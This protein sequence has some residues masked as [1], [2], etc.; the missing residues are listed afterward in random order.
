MTEW[1]V[2]DLD[3]APAGYRELRTD[4]VVVP[5]FAPSVFAIDGADAVE[6]LQGQCTNDLHILGPQGLDF[7]FTKPTGQILTLCR[8]WK[9]GD[10]IVVA[11]DDPGV[12]MARVD[13]TVIM[14]DVRLRELGP[15]TCVQGPKCTEDAT[16]SF[17]PGDWTGSGG[18][19][20]VSVPHSGLASLSEG[21]WN[22]ATLESGQPIRGKDF[23]ER[24]LPPELGADFEGRFV[25]YQKGCYTGQEVLM[26]IKSRGHT[27]K[28]W[29]A[30]RSDCVLEPGSTVVFEDNEVGVVHRSANS[31]NF[32]PIASATLLNRATKNGSIV[33]V[34]GAQAVVE[35]YPLTK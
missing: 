24:T 19:L 16:D 29:V 3:R 33:S 25:S 23:G 9:R 4:A 31:P 18:Y 32:G 27:N 30:L 17:L 10:D 14:E 34:S 7:C 5:Q 2:A 13:Q 11:V 26:R 8:A 6:W 20:S 22:L 15:A 21:A 12:L 35:Q 28:T 1:T